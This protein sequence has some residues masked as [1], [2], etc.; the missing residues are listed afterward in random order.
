MMTL[1]ALDRKIFYVHLMVKYHFTDRRRKVLLRWHWHGVRSGGWIGGKKE[2][3]RYRR[4]K[5]L[6]H[7]YLI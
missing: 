5:I 7:D 2:D 6:G 4:S 3:C 1:D